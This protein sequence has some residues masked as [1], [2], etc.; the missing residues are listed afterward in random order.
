MQKAATHDSRFPYGLIFIFLLFAAGIIAGGYLNYR[1]YAQRF[2]REVEIKLSTIAD[3]KVAQIVHWRK[4]RLNDGAFLFKNPLFTELVRKFLAGRQDPENRES[5]QNWLAQYQEAF[6]YENI[7]LLDAQGARLLSTPAESTFDCGILPGQIPEILR[8]GMICFLDLHRHAADYALHL[9]VVVPVL[10][11][12]RALGLVCMS[13]NPET[14]LYPLIS[15]WPT[16]TK[17]AE[18]LLVRRDGGDAL[19]LNEL[20]FKKDTA[21]KLRIPLTLVSTPAVQAALGHEGI[22]DGVDYRGVPVIADVR[23]VPDSPWF[24]VARMD[25]EEVYAPMKERLWLGVLFIMALLFAAGTA[26]LFFWRQQ[27]VRFYKDRAKEAEALRVSEHKLRAVLDSTPFPIALVDRQDA[28]IYFWSRSAFDLFGHTAATTPEWYELAYPDPEYRR[29]VIGRW[30]PFLETARQSG[31]PVNT[32]EYRVTCSNGSERICELH[33]FFLVDSLIVTFNDITERKKMETQL[34]V[35][36]RIATIFSTASDEEMYNEVLQVIL[37]VMKSPFG[38]FGYLDKDG[39]NVVPTMTRQIWDKCQVPEKSIRFPRKTWGDSSWCR[40]I[41]EKRTISSN[42]PSVNIPE[43][44]VGIQKHISLPI[45]LQGNPIGL[46]QVANKETDYTDVDL[47]LLQN[48]ADHVAPILN[49]RLGRERYEK[50]LQETNAEL[51]RFNYTISH[52]LKS[53][54]VTVKTFLG[55]LEKDMQKQDAGRMEK[56]FAYIRGAADKMGRLLDELLQLSRIGRMVNPS[57]DASLQDIVREALCLVAGRIA[58]R[59][60]KVEVT[61]TPLLL[62]GDRPRLVEVFQNLIDNA[63]KFM[64]DQKEPKIEI[65]LK[66]KSGEKLLFVRDNGMGIDPRYHDKLFGLFEKLNPEVEGTGMGLAL[67]KRIVEVHG[68]KIWVESEGLGKGAC[69][70]FSLP[71]G[72]SSES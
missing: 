11:Q 17:T 61:Q 72:R 52:D 69:F 44:H 28:N 8:R 66:V 51:T 55:Y 40:A 47:R 60:V 22:V 3:L 46:F 56:D 12:D 7:F 1:D 32:G 24:M 21:L 37:D 20:R 29:E 70:W 53:P 13:I 42:E 54:L 26:L 62:S 23:A 35:L 57:V 31:R 41:R 14:Y 9:A 67:V 16:P 65:G 45:L 5:L 50:E 68:G 4:E 27:R 34:A 43:G 38:V 25:T 58:E 2:R 39:A 71:K 59:G 48:I 63:V 64:G 10:D 15:R 18:T 36:A 19:F 33:A 6:N 30:N 49:A